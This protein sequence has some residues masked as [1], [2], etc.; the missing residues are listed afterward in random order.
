M[1][2]W[3]WPA[4]V[5]VVGGL[6]LFA[7]LFLPAVVWQSRRYGRLSVLRLIGTAALA[8]YG[9]ALVAY[10]LLPLPSGDL[11][12]WCA[13]H[14]VGGAQ[15][16]PFQFVADIRRDTAG[17]S[18]AATLRSAAVLQVVFNVLLF[19]PWGIFAR[20]FAGWGVLRSTLTGALAS[21]AIEV[22]Q[23]TGVFG[24][25]GCSYRIGDV[26][27][28]MTNT[29][30]ALLGALAA[31]L[32]LRWMPRPADLARDRGAP[33]PVSTL[34]RW[35]GMLVDVVSVL[36]LGAALGIGWGLAAH[37]IDGR[38]IAAPALVS[39]WFPAAVL[40]WLPPP[41]RL[42][43]LARP[44]GD[45]AGTALAVGLRRAGARQP[46]PARAAR[47]LRRRGVGAAQRT[48][49]DRPGAG[50]LRARDRAGGAV[51]PRP[52]RVVLRPDRRRAG[53]RPQPG[54]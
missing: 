21:L 43:C 40:L 7:A 50:D 47:V 8:V 6:L 49:R 32:V 31:P 51:Q 41:G 3:T 27:D 23:Y 53:R 10:T 37:L 16:H 2:R 46:A 20:G 36:V 24:L 22:T 12:L 25:I 39:T 19:L 4:W 35:L 54:R 15:L 29:L 5:G 9:T 45:V 38:E 52:P 11:T 17:M 42:R 13:E 1:D 33:R 48:G 18:L 28:L 30:G 34:R 14:G 44:A 26:D